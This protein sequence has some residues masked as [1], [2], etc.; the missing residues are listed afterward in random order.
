MKRFYKLRD[1]I[2]VDLDSITMV[3]DRGYSMT[4][5]EVRIYTLDGRHE[6]LLSNEDYTRLYQQLEKEKVK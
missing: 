5:H 6:Y 3:I 1:D 4:N 2:L